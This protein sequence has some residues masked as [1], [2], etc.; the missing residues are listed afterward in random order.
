MF[1]IRGFE[2]KNLTSTQWITCDFEKQGILSYFLK[3]NLL[4]S[5]L[6]S[7]FASGAFAF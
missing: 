1:E 5:Q 4:L 7:S 3:S 2:N 6:L